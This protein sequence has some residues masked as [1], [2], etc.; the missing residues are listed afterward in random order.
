VITAEQGALGVA[1]TST[2]LTLTGL[3]EGL[4][5]R[6]AATPE[7]KAQKF[8][9]K[10][11]SLATPGGRCE[12]CEGRGVITVAMDLLPDVTTGCEVCEGKRFKPEVLACRLEGR[13]IAEVMEA[14]VAEAR[15]IFPGEAR[16]RALTELGLGYLPLGQGGGALSAGERQRL[17]LALLLAEP[18]KEQVAILLDEPTRG[19]GLEDVD[20][21]VAGLQVLAGQGHLVVAVT[22]DLDLIAASDWVIDLG[23]EG[24]AAGGRVIIEGSPERV[25]ACES[26]H[27]GRAL[28]EASRNPQD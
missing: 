16:L 3:G 25:A 24:G 12:A 20:R 15:A 8:T 2:V 7:A 10:H 17:R 13:N 22:H 14:T 4:R 18:P 28:A 27:T 19:L 1:A 11:F 26:S 21:L 23:P 5:K 6:F 9:A